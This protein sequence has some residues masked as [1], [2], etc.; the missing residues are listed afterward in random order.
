MLSLSTACVAADD[1]P[2]PQVLQDLL[3][4][5]AVPV[6][7]DPNFKSLTPESALQRND[8]PIIPDLPYTPSTQPEQVPGG[9]QIPE[10]PLP[11]E[12]GL[13]LAPIPPVPNNP[14]QNLPAGT[15]G[16]EAPVQNYSN[17][18][19]LE[20]Y[21][22]NTFTNTLTIAQMGSKAGIPL[23]AGQTSS[24]IDFT[25][26]VDKVIT[27]AKMTVHVSITEAMAMRGSHLEVVLNSQPVGTLPLTDSTGTATFE[28]Y[29]PYE[30]FASVNT[31]IFNIDDPELACQVDYSNRYRVVILPDSEFILE[32]HELEVDD[33][34]AIFPLPFIDPYDVTK[35]EV[36]I[37]Y[38]QNL[39]EDMVSASAILASW[40]G[41]RADYRGIK[42]KTHINSIPKAHAIIF[43]KPGEEIGGI[44]MPD[45]SGIS[46]IRNPVAN[47]YKL[48]L[49]TG[50][51]IGELRDDVRILTSL[52]I[53]GHTKSIPVEHQSIPLREAYDANKWIPTNRKVYL[54]ELLRNDQSLVSTG[55]W[56]SP[57]MIN[58]RAAPDLYQLYGMP[59]YLYL[60]YNFPL[61]NSIN[62]NESWLN[63]TLSGNFIDNLP[64]NKIGILE[65]LWR[66]SGGDGRLEERLIP[67][68]PYMIYGD[69]SLDLYFDLKLKRSASCS[70]LHDSNIKSI[71]SD[72]S[73]LDLSNTDHYA[74]LPNLSFF[75]GASFPFTKYADYAETVMLLPAKPS[76]TEIKVLL[77]MAARAGNATGNSITYNT[78]IFG[79][80]ELKETPNLFKDK[81]IMVVSSLTQKSLMEPL[82]Q[83]SAFKFNGSDLAIKN[84]NPFSSEG[85]FLN[86]IPRLLVGDFRPENLDANR[87]LSSNVFWRGFISLVSPWDDERIVV[88]AT[89]S[90][91]Q[92]LSM[93]SDDL[94]NPEIN[95]SI[96]GDVSLITG[97]D[98]IRSFRVGDSIYTGNVSF[99]FHLLH[100]AGT[101]VIWLSVFS[102]VFLIF[103]G[104][105]LSSW[106]KN[107]ARKRTA[108]IK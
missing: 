58:F 18:D 10:Y 77:D 97:K 49:I 96:S 20:R 22:D 28:L 72:K 16:N 87:Y 103:F 74:R 19:E 108:G 67:I 68:Q 94:D 99:M 100:F 82:I 101:H 104:V 4:P 63:V 84:L 73:Y 2:Q 57:I 106:L 3:N 13:N 64:V 86:S 76:P 85:S 5:N 56:H 15:A 1:A 21:Q 44:T 88:V 71:I 48:I 9:T 55:V 83:D 95:R 43:G 32:G 105:I 65:N 75:V 51:N 40:L 46:I 50:E 34:L 90:N 12:S 45:T 27:N 60:D 102:F 30:L 91:D 29:L 78:V 66:L 17:T 59:V 23:G 61:E 53:P 98:Q 38:S 93:I 54:T 92:Q 47:L 42:F 37:V 39:R 107:R 26:P 7:V 52:S 35:A 69:N 11:G 14:L 62:E 24:G 79:L 41:I 70:L 80:D 81:D 25:L 8:L 31:L 89:A 36:D 6:G 33:D